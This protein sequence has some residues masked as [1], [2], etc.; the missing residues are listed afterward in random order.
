MSQELWKKLN[1]GGSSETIISN[2]ESLEFKDNWKASHVGHQQRQFVNE[3]LKQFKEGKV[4]YVYNGFL[5]LISLI[6]GDDLSFLDVGCATGYYGEIAAHKYPNKLRYSGCDY[7]EESINVAKSYYKNT[8][9]SVQDIT[10]MK[11]EDRQFDA[12]MVSGV[13]EHVPEQEKAFNETARI[14]KDWIICHR[15]GLTHKEEHFTKGSQYDTPVVKYYFN[16]DKFIDRFTNRG[17]ALKAFI[18]VYPNNDNIQSY[19][20][21]RC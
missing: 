8:P 21:R 5:E 20:F 18:N 19:L 9:F 13:F 1:P 10:D 11:F 3:E 12:V 2:E 4:P 6:E 16:R 7:N 17:F 14:T 15:I